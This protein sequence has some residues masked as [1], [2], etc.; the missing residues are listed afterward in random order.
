MMK[1]NR[2][3]SNAKSSETRDSYPDIQVYARN[4]VLR[5]IASTHIQISAPKF[6]DFIRNSFASSGYVEKKKR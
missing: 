1:S 3:I 6:K 2:K 4:N 5:L